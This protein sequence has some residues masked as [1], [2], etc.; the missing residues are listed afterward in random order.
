MINPKRK[1]ILILLSISFLSSCLTVPVEHVPADTDN[2]VQEVQNEESSTS[3][4]PVPA[5]DKTRETPVAWNDVIAFGAGDPTMYEWDED[6]LNHYEHP[7]HGQLIQ[8]DKAGPE[9]FLFINQ[10]AFQGSGHIRG[11][12]VDWYN[13]SDSK[14]EMTLDLTGAEPVVLNAELGEETGYQAMGRS[15]WSDDVVYQ[16]FFEYNPSDYV[17]TYIEWEENGVLFAVGKYRAVK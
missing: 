4:E 9:F 10:G 3:S 6:A 2:S 11:V 8:P 1:V 15:N 5:Q 14:V 13:G 12:Q 7:V 17:L 16:I